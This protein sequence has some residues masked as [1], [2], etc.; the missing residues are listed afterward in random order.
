MPTHGPDPA[1]PFAPLPA[2]PTAPDRSSRGRLV[3]AIGAWTFVS[4][5]TATLA[6]LGGALPLVEANLVGLVAAAFL[7]VP[8]FVLPRHVEDPTPPTEGASAWARALRIAALTSLVTAALYLP[9][10]HL[11]ET[12]IFAGTFQPSAD[13]LQRPPDLWRGWPQG[14]GVDDGAVHLGEDNGRWQL[15]WKAQA[16]DAPVQIVTDGRFERV[17]PPDR[18]ADGSEPG[19]LIVQPRPGRILQQRWSLR[20]AS[21]IEV[22]VPDGV[23]LTA[24]AYDGPVEAGG[25]A[26]RIPL[27]LRWL[28]WLALTHT[29]LIALP[30]EFFYRGY[31]QARL[32]QT[33]AGAPVLRLLGF[34]VTR[35]NLLTSLLFGL[36]HFV[37]GWSPWRLAV[38]F[39]SLLFGAMR[40][41]S[42]GVVASTVFHAFCNV[43]ALSM[44]LFYG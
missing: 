36:A 32:H 14:A 20:D 13:V 40:D 41:R 8:R 17:E 44:G 5:L 34:E 33:L 4:A 3:E 7:L 24:G 15:L 12:K 43:M 11:W 25:G 31:L 18:T 23:A 10:R 27:R 9:G 35:A 42:G 21:W 37:V 26:H 6:M 39:P 28:L 19:V 29:L 30:E 1:G 16:D 2:L 38:F 22:Q